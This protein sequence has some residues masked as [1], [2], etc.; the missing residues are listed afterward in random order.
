MKNK[1]YELADWVAFDCETTGK[2]P[3]GDELCEIAAVKWSQGVIVD[4]FQRLLPISRPMPKEVIQIHGITDEMLKG[5]RPIKETLTDFIKFI[6]GSICMAHH[7]PFDLGFLVAA[8]E[9]QSLNLPNSL[10]FCTSLLARNRIK[11]TQNHKLQTLAKHYDI[12]PG[13]AHRALDD[14]RVCLDVM[15]RLFAEDKDLADAQVLETEI[16][17]HQMKWSDYSI[18]ELQ[19][20]PW[21]SSI[22]KA[23]VQ[24]GPI[25]MSYLGGSRPGQYRIVRPVGV[26]RNPQGDFLAAYEG[27]SPQPKRY[28][29]E[30]IDDAIFE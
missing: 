1:A 27:Q 25:K 11:G 2:Y 22:L 29:L 26:V 5:A 9:Q 14:A 30:K 10:V 7:A 8:F 4:R 18:L 24:R 12:D 23:I 28:L 20:K 13:Q 19:K 3:V 16:R 21:I 15:L 17:Q 6:S